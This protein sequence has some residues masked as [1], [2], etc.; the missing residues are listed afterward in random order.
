VTSLLSVD[1]LSVAFGDLHAL[2]D[3]SFDLREAS[4]TGLIGPN[5]AGKTTLLDVVSGYVRPSRGSVHIAGTRVDDVTPHRRAALGLGRTFQ[6]VELFDDLSVAENLLVATEAAGTG[7]AGARTA[8]AAVGLTPDDRRL[9]AALA[10]GER[11]RLAMARALAGRPRLLLL[12]EPAAGL[13]AAERRE[14]V[15]LLPQIAAGGTAV[16]LVDHDLGLVLD[17]C[18]RVLVLDF[19]RL[20]ADGR[21]SDIRDGPAVAAA[22]VGAAHAETGRPRTSREP[23]RRPAGAVTPALTVSG[24]TAGYGGA[25]VVRD[26]DLQVGEGEIVA[27]LGPNGAGKTTT[28]LAVS[29]AVPRVHGD[30]RVLGEPLRGGGFR[31]ARRG[32]A[33]VLQDHRVFAGLSAQDNLRLMTSDRAAVEEA[34]DLLPGLRPVLRRPAG[35]LS[36]GEQ[37]LLALARALARRPRL[38]VVDELSLGLAPAVVADLMPALSGLAEAGTA[39]LLA[40]Q[41]ADLALA[42]ADRA[43][44]LVAGRIVIADT[45]AALAADPSRL[46]SAYLGGDQR[47]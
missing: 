44:V 14:L 35:R 18:D 25:P 11:K 38:L 42:V 17:S 36:G 5:G 6:S 27:L 19:G 45:A 22:Y 12:D 43:Y 31:Q 46:A 2:E 9:A 47:L 34:L 30:V 28:L 4:V 8:A 23:A 20:I 37:Q 1:G 41:H 15:A 7:A 32:V 39:I 10:P 16:L 24:L 13:D 26:V 33:H 21:P 3:V 29:G 40:E